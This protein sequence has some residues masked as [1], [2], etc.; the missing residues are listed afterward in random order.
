MV[1]M[2]ISELKRLKYNS[3][4]WK[5]CAATK[6]TLLERD[7][8]YSEDPQDVKL[9][10]MVNEDGFPL[11]LSWNTWWLVVKGHILHLLDF[12]RRI[13]S[14]IV[15]QFEMMKEKLDHDL[16]THNVLWTSSTCGLW[17]VGLWRHGESSG[18]ESM[19]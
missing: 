4:R 14:H 16:I 13:E 12:S 8:V 11:M 6:T 17:L 9:V 18:Y 19:K 15:K 2:S 3:N 10:I 7:V 5:N 1:F